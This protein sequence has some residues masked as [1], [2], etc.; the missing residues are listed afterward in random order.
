M[1]PSRCTY[2]RGDTWTAAHTAQTIARELSLLLY[3]T[4]NLARLD[5]HT[6]AQLMQAAEDCVSAAI[7]DHAETPAEGVDDMQAWR[8][9]QER[10]AG[11]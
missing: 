3:G 6:R 11:R 1:T 9:K 8:D 2:E 7:E 10:E 4:I 5:P